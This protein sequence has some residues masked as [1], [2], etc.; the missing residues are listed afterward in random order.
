M[1]ELR[2]AVE[3]FLETLVRRNDS[4]HTIR[5]YGAD[6]DEFILYFSPSGEEPPKPAEIDLLLLREWLAHLYDRQQKPATIRRKLASVRAFFKYLSRERVIERD[7][8]RL[9]R[10]PKVPKTL[11]PVP[12]AEITNALVDGVSE[13]R[14]EKPFPLRDTLMFELLYGC[15]LRISEV[16]GLNVEDFDRTE[17]WIRVRGKGRK[18]RQVPFGT[19]AGEALDA[20]LTPDRPGSGPLLLNF[21]GKRLSAGGARAI[22]KFYAVNVAGDSSIHPHTLRHA[23][24]THLLSDGADL[25]SIQELLGH[26]RLS[27]TQKYTQVALADLMRVYDKAHPHAK[28]SGRI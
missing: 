21:R 13:D 6:L 15:G 5:N 25:R 22:V 4:P 9:L 26:A 27:T 23:F 8:A 17:K 7:P 18:M 1:S 12:N 20:Y 14:Y 2:S 10:V 11:P 3:A 28:L 19:K 16:V 24:A